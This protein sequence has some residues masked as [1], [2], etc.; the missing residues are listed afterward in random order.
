MIMYINLHKLKSF[1]NVTIDFSGST[2]F[3]HLFSFII[4]NVKH[5]VSQYEFKPEG[6]FQ[7]WT[8]KH[9]IL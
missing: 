4:S 9:S 3:D 5:E 2:S 1:D 7:N 8:L 6:S